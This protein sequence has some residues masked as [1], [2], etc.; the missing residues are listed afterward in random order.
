MPGRV[1]SVLSRTGFNTGAVPDA[2]R[3]RGLGLRLLG[4]S[5]G[6]RVQGELAL[7]RSRFV[8]P[9]DPALALDG[10]LQPVQPETRNAALAALRF[11]L[12]QQ[13]RVGTQALD[14]TLDVRHERA[15]DAAAAR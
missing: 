11:A 6:G 4:T 15:L 1:A 3:S 9:F 2:E 10:E 14:L 5:E 13:A 7:A 8:N 12:L